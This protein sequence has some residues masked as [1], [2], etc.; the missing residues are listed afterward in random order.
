MD[1]NGLTLTLT[2]NLRSE[3]TAWKDWKDLGLNSLTLAL[4]PALSPRAEPYPQVRLLDTAG[5][6]S[7]GKYR[8]KV[9]SQPGG[10]ARIPTGFRPPAQGGET[11]AIWVVARPAAPT[12]MR[13]RPPLFHSSRPTFATTPVGLIGIYHRL[14]RVG[15]R[16]RQ[17]WALRHNPF[18][19]GRILAP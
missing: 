6:Q 9:R 11:R 4:T 17:P 10:Y 5:V 3:F 18:G 19:I 2:M 16:T 15:S 12:A 1:L 14:P 13:L 8:A 7:V